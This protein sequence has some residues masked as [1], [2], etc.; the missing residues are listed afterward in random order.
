MTEERQ[1]MERLEELA[2]IEGK[3]EGSERKDSTT[4][5]PMTERQL[6]R[7]VR[8]WFEDR[9]CECGEYEMGGLTFCYRCKCFTR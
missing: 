6:I 7:D 2:E 9:P 1:L 3:R 8:G 4:S 5:T